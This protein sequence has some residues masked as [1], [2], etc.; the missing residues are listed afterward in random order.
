MVGTSKM[1]S[2]Y[3]FSYYALVNYKTATDECNIWHPGGAQ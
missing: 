3:Y 1:E 2:I